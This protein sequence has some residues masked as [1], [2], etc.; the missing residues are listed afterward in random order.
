MSKYISF[1]FHQ[2]SARQEVK[3]QK[4]IEEEDADYECEEKDD[5]NDSD[6]SI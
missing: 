4:N 6:Y 5:S 3:P 1:V 2:K